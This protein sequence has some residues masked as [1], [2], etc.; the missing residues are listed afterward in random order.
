MSL[1]EKVRA[2]LKAASEWSSP[3]ERDHVALAEGIWDWSV[4]VIKACVMDEVADGA[5]GFLLAVLD[6][7]GLRDGVEDT[8]ESFAMRSKQVILQ[9]VVEEVSR[10][11]QPYHK[12]LVIAASFFDW[13]TFEPTAAEDSGMHAPGGRTGATDGGLPK[14]LRRIT[15]G[16]EARSE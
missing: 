1:K 5:F 16:Q 7:F 12:R 4:P 10:R 2:S 15:G 8:W 13:I 14:P 3:K 6:F 9:L 11:L